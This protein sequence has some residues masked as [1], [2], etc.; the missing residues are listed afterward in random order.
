MTK[1]FAALPTLSYFGVPA[2]NFLA[3]AKLS[4]KT[5]ADKSLYYPYTVGEHERVDIISSKYYDDPDYAWLIWMTNSVVDPYY[6]VYLPESDFRNFITKKY[7][8]VESAQANVAYWVNAWSNDDTELSV[9]EYDALPSTTQKYYDPITDPNNVVYQYARKRED[10]KATTNRIVSMA[11]SDPGTNDF[12]V[13]SLVSQRYV[14]NSLIT[15]TGTVVFSNSSACILNHT[16]GDFL[17]SNSSVMLI[18]YNETDA[19][20]TDSVDT[21]KCIPDAEI[22]FWSSV[23]YYDHEV[24]TN[25]SRRDIHLIDNRFKNNI[26]NQLKN[27]MAE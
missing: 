15:G 13:G 12:P 11:I 27:V 6:D 2:K 25:A 10:W 5:L 19:S 18:L 9:S 21:Q 3:V 16:S 26:T 1:F 7:G 14:S 4:D 8:S 22:A 24:A 20:I 17:A 23:S